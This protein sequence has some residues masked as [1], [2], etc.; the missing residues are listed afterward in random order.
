MKKL[1][2]TAVMTFGLGFIG[3]VATANATLV[4]N[5]GGCDFSSDP[6][7]TGTC[8]GS[9]ADLPDN[10]LNMAFNQNGVDTVRLA[11]DADGMP[12]GTGKIKGIWFNVDN[13]N[14]S[15]LTFSYVS[16]VATND[17]TPGGNVFGAVGIFD[18][19]FEYKTSGPLGS[20]FYN[21]TSVYDISG[22]GLLENDFNA[23]SSGGY[24]AV[25]HVNITGNGESGHYVSPVPEPASMLLIG[26]GLVGI[27]GS[28]LRRRKKA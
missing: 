10:A 4:F 13:L 28:R 26:T 24:N 7:G 18:I 19:N 1:L 14:F 22:T 16:G 3:F 21:K 9:G 2:L 5:L 23:L 27:A 17:I 11:I 25:M 15:D 6:G 8:G 12:D 20:L